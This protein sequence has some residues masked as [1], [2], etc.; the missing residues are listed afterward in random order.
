MWSREVDGQ[1]L[2]FRLLGVNNQ[3]FLMADEQTGSWWQQ[4]TGEAVQGPLAGKRL[5]RVASDEVRF[6]VWRSEHPQTTLLAPDARFAERYLEDDWEAKV[7]DFDP[8]P[9]DRDRAGPLAARDV[10]IG[11]V[12]GGEAK[13]YPRSLLAAQSPIA[14]FLGGVPIVVVLDAGGRSARA[15]ERRVGDQTL[16]LFRVADSDPVEMIDAESGSTW[17]FAG[18]ARS[19]ALAGSRLARVQTLTSFWFDWR[20]QNPGT[21]VFAAGIAVAE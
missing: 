2:T 6:A 1:V 16:E 8:P 11:V 7:A 18:E 13:A 19:G 10:V 3:N 5:A 21:T 12:A 17:S 9:A 20:N 14:D 4:V 15:F